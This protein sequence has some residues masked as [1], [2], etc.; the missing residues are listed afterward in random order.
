MSKR[1]CTLL[2]AG[3]VLLALVFA[4]PAEAKRV[5]DEKLDMDTLEKMAATGQIIH[6][7]YRGNTLIN[8]MVCTLVN[9][10]PDKVW[11]VITGFSKYYKFIPFMLPPAVTKVAPN[12]FRVDFTLDITIIGP[13][14]TTMKYSIEYVLEKP[15]LYM[16][17]NPDK[18]KGPKAEA[19]YWKVV[20]V[21]GGKKTLLF[22][23]DKP[24]DLA[25]MGLLV[26]NII[27]SQP[28]ISV[29]LQVSPV[30]IAV[31]EIKK[32]SERMK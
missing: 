18:P 28:A 12:D 22:Y 6:L 29:G 26:A 24:P 9:A 25:K 5:L 23:L 20:P 27:R 15:Y 10:P 31:A 2:C 13:I 32:Y 8:R 16:Y 1:I 4:G 11:G 17:D 19:N 3:V 21:E 14:K 30:S 7:E